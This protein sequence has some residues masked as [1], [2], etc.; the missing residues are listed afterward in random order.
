MPKKPRRAFRRWM[1]LLVLLLLAGAVLMASGL[2][3]YE[4]RIFRLKAPQKA[5]VSRCIPGKNVA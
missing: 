3:G 1:L 4:H 2:R 5:G